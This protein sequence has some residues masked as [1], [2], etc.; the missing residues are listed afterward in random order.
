VWLAVLPN[1]QDERSETH[2]RR[3]RQ[4][5]GEQIAKIAQHERVRKN[6]WARFGAG[7][8]VRERSQKRLC[9]LLGKWFAIAWVSSSPTFAQT[10]P[11]RWKLL[12]VAALLHGE[13]QVVKQFGNF[14]STPL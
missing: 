4:R 1:W 9:E 2:V 14:P 6:G 8:V 7:G 10:I 13:K 12:C 5:R 11:Y 3:A